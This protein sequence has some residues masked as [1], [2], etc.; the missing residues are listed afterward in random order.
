[1]ICALTQ[2]WSSSR[3][4]C[5]QGML[6]NSAAFGER[7]RWWRVKSLFIKGGVKSTKGLPLIVVDKT[8]KRQSRP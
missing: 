3:K 1:M 6:A 8:K 7:L 5:S 2:A 4:T